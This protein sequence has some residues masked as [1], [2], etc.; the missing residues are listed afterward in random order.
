MYKFLNIEQMFEEDLAI[1]NLSVAEKEK[2]KANSVSILNDI[3]DNISKGKQEKALNKFIKD[4]K[5]IERGQELYEV[6]SKISNAKIKNNELKLILDAQLITNKY[7]VKDYDYVIKNS[8]TFLNKYKNL[9]KFK[10]PYIAA[11]ISIYYIESFKKQAKLENAQIKIEEF[12]NTDMSTF[13]KGALLLAKHEIEGDILLLERAHDMFLQVGAFSNAI[14]ALFLYANKVALYNRTILDKVEERFEFLTNKSQK[15]PDFIF[16]ATYYYGLIIKY[17]DMREYE[18]ATNYAFKCLNLILKIDTDTARDLL[19]RTLGVISEL[20]NL[21]S[22]SVDDLGSKY[23]YNIK[24][25]EPEKVSKNDTDC[26]DISSLNDLDAHWATMEAFYHNK[27]FSR[28]DEL[29]EKYKDNET[30]LAM[31][32]LRYAEFNTSLTSFKRIEYLERA[33]ALTKDFTYFD[34]QRAHIFKVYCSIFYEAQDFK[35]YLKYAS[36]YLKIVAYDIDFNNNYVQLLKKEGLW[37]ELESFCYLYSERVGNTPNNE[38]LL[39]EALYNQNKDLNK[40]LTLIHKHRD[41]AFSDERKQILKE[42]ETDLLKRN[43]QVDYDLLNKKQNIV[44]TLNNFEK[45]LDE[46]VKYVEANLRKD[47]SKYSKEEKKYKWIQEPEKKCKK[48]LKMFLDVTFKDKIEVIEEVSIG[49]G[50]IDL[51]IKFSGGLE[52]VIELKMSGQGYTTGYAKS[53]IEQVKHYLKNKQ[54]KLGYL[55]V[56]DARI[57]KNGTEIPSNIFNT[58]CTIFTRFV[59]MRMDAKSS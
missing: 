21:M 37:I 50:F 31:I 12:L 36:E 53:G 42:I 41:V 35:R 57:E 15:I 1:N 55:I 18:I 46:Y 9:L 17:K 7:S 47:Y 49:A 22:I 24:T 40:V 28:L 3:K 54:T 27:D 34:Q 4:G 20:S 26:K 16:L 43:C 2:I 30:A 13:A 58:D 52:I 32:Y 25:I 19:F 45:A 56:Y 38:T 8:E 51:Y 10:Y 33:K 14:Q 59:D 29:E 44:V 48:D 23:N 5:Y 6:L 39:I 11:R